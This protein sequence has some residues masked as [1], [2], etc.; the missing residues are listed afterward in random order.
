MGWTLAA[1][2][3]RLLP[4]TCDHHIER[5]RERVANR[6]EAVCPV[7]GCEEAAGIATRVLMSLCS[8]A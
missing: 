6:K 3:C 2:L 1:S 8:R 4:L 7:R 5:E